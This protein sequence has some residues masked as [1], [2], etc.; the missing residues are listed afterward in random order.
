VDRLAESAPELDERLATHLAQ[1]LATS[2]S[3]VGETPR[4]IA[5]LALF[6]DSLHG[7][8]ALSV[9]IGGTTLIAAW[10]GSETTARELVEDAAYSY[11]QQ[12]ADDKWLG[13]AP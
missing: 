10:D 11:A 4:P 5:D 6:R 7:Q 1:T 3:E 8:P 9:R 12:V 2:M 13:G